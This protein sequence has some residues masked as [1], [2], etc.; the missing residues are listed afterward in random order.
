[1]VAGNAGLILHCEMCGTKN[2]LDPYAFFNFSGTTKCAGCD[3]VYAITLRSGY[4]TS[5]PE[6]AS[7][8][9][10]RLPGYAESKDF[11]PVTGPGKTAASPKAQ[12]QMVGRPKPISQSIRGKPVSGRPLTK[13]ELVGSRPRFVVEG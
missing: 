5:G 2:Y 12:A 8:E 9:V 6:R 13:E 3:Q 1:V 4:V 10:D 11:E 7:G